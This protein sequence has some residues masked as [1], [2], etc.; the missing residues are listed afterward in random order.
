VSSPSLPTVLLLIGVSG[1]GKT[2]VGRALADRLGWEFLDADDYHP[3]SNVA[4]MQRGEGLTDADRAPW[5]DALRRLIARR[6]AQ[7]APAVLA[8]SALKANYRAQLRHGDPRVTI[9]WLD[10]DPE[11][12][13]RRLEAREGHF[14]GPELLASQFEALEPPTPDEAVRIAVEGDVDQVARRV[15]DALRAETTNGSHDDA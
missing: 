5:L 10:V 15:I 3:P 11:T 7:H 14:A 8:C 2:A 9:V 4:K 6:L 1:A 13:A 12:I